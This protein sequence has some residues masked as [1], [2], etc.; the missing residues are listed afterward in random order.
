[1]VGKQNCLSG[2]SLVET[3]FEYYA[4]Y[5]LLWRHIR[6]RENT[7]DPKLHYCGIS[8]VAIK[9][10]LEYC[11]AAL[12]PTVYFAANKMHEISDLRG[13]RYGGPALVD[14]G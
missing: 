8:G 11:T 14:R 2:R 6:H 5:F 12:L 1:L 4:A 9:I 7:D 10:E 3:R 13:F